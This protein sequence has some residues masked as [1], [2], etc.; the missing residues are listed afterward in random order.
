MTMI[1]RKFKLF[2]S[3]SMF[4]LICALL[5]SSCARPVPGTDSEIPSAQEQSETQSIPSGEQSETQSIPSGEQ[6]GSESLETSPSETTEEPSDASSFWDRTTGPKPEAFSVPSAY[7]PLGNGLYDTKIR[8]YDHSAGVQVSSGYMH[9]VDLMKSERRLFDL[10]TGLDLGRSY[11]PESCSW[12]ALEDGSLYLYNDR[13]MKITSVGRDGKETVVREDIPEYSGEHAPVCETI[14]PDGRYDFCYFSDRGILRMEDLTDGRVKEIS[15]P[16]GFSSVFGQRGE[17]F[18]LLLWDGRFL[19][20]DLSGKAELF[21]SEM[22]S[23][24]FKLTNVGAFY[25]STETMTEFLF[26]DPF[27][28]EDLALITLD[29]AMAEPVCV[30]GGF[31]VFRLL[32]DEYPYLIADLRTGTV[33][34]A[35]PLPDMMY[36]SE[37]FISDEG[38]ALL[39][40]ECRD[41]SAAP[42][43][44]DL[45]QDAAEENFRM[46]ASEISY[47]EMVKEIESIRASLLETEGIELFYG[48]EGNDFKIYGYV[49]Q[50]MLNPLSIYLNVRDFC[51]VIRSYPEGMIREAWE[52]AGFSGIRCYLCSSLYGV[53]G[54]GLSSAG[55]VTSDGGSHIIVAF[56]ADNATLDTDIPHE[57]SHVFDRRIAKATEE[58]GIEWLK[59]F[60]KIT[61]HPYAESYPNYE[62]LTRWTKDQSGASPSNVWYIDSY[63]RTFSTEDR[64]RIM[65][66][67]FDPE[68]N[69][70]EEIGEY[71]HIIYKAKAYCVIL[72]ACFNSL[73]DADPVWEKWLD[74]EGFDWQPSGNA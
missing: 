1:N 45:S 10:S 70:L 20:T 67:L 13:G 28:P 4:L 54:D 48:S 44:F 73:K 27:R 68:G 50:V 66:A 32:S 47:D 24:S 69:G 35:K 42:L 46:T 40:F 71:E 25:R 49:G 55:A 30:S 61:P 43:L 74:L 52:D 5:L 11:F 36:L 39:M 34:S 6:S 65:E 3:V 58:T 37:A 59:A 19:R 12:T 22:M 41:G 38:F 72:R 18:L 14:T 15:I 26:F 7:E 16:T 56:N 33:L 9:L 63:S 2:S 60:E 17:D 53:S 21:E 62:S 57:F 51:K 23:D 8:I 31:G 64:A 29:V